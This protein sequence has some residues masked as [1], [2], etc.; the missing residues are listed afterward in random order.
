M[1]IF[2]MVSVGAV[3][4][5]STIASLYKRA[6]RATVAESLNSDTS[7]PLSFDKASAGLLAK[8]R[9]ASSRSLERWLVK[10]QPEAIN[11]I[12]IYNKALM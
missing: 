3:S 10:A 11:T 12:I 9:R 4:L 8:S 5:F 1:A 2:I 7:M 6:Q